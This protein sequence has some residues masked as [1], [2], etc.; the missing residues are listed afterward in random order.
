MSKTALSWKQDFK[1]Q[2]GEWEWTAVAVAA[3]YKLL[4]PFSVV[5][6]GAASPAVF[7]IL[8]KPW[9]EILNCG[10]VS[11]GVVYPLIR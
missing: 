7:A 8:P 4:V 9:I 10:A 1:E 5:L 2:P 6:A 11:K 3:K